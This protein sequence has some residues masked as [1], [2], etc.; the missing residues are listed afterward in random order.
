MTK[1]EIT[2]ER[3]DGTTEKVTKD[4][5]FNLKQ[6]AQIT[7]ATKTAGRGQIVGWCEYVQPQKHSS[8]SRHCC[9]HYV[10]GQGCPLH[11]DAE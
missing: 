1:T 6:R 7:E 11:G 3:P 5:A 4:G 10:V 2:I 9:T 8:G